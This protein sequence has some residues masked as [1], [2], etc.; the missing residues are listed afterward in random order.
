MPGKRMKDKDAAEAAVETSGGN[1][2]QPRRS[3]MVE[4]LEALIARVDAYH[5]TT[6]S[7]STI[8]SVTRELR[9]V[10]GRLREIEAA[11]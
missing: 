1:E 2:D 11:G 5:A 10:E 3:T 6:A 8:R 7:S 9:S 4:D